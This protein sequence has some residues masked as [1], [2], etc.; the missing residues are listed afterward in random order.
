MKIFTDIVLRI[1]VADSDDS[2][3]IEIEIPH[4][5]LSYS[6][7]L[8][9]C[10]QELCVKE[11]QVERIRKLPNIRLRNDNDVKRLNDLQYL[12]IVLYNVKPEPRPLNP[13]P[14]IT[15]CKNQTILY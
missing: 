14:L 6:S 11:T 15:T 4:K 12:E 7:L 3:Y 1:R 8:S 9:I 10:C 13:Y 2:D 5:K